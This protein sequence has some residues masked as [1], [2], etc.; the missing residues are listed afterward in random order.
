MSHAEHHPE[1]KGAAFA[2]L[3]GGMVFVGAVMLGI[4]LWTNA[5]FAGHNAEKAAAEAPKS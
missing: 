3:I 2:G 4:T 5:K 1:D